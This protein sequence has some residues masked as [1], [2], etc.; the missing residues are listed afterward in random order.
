M[1][2]SQQSLHKS[3]G[4]VLLNSPGK[5]VGILSADTV[6]QSAFQFVSLFRT[7]VFSYHGNE[8]DCTVDDV[9]APAFDNKVPITNSVHAADFIQNTSGLFTQAVFS[10]SI[11]GKLQTNFKLD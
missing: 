5:L 11:Y 8:I 9:I 1:K 3:L 4:F 10:L 7:V 6:D 2:K